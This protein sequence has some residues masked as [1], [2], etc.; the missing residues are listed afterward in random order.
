MQ[1]NYYIICLLFLNFSMGID[2]DNRAHIK[3]LIRFWDKARPKRKSLVSQGKIQPVE[4]DKIL[5]E[6]F[7][8]EPGG[9]G[10]LI[11]GNG[12]ET[13]KPEV[14]VDTTNIS[15]QYD[16]GLEFKNQTELEIHIWEIH[17]NPCK[18]HDCGKGFASNLELENHECRYTA[19]A[20]KKISK[21]NCSH[22]EKTFMTKI[23]YNY[24][25]Q[26]GRYF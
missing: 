15:C 23:G 7:G 17:E 13:Q 4:S 14:K 25:V 3:C 2:V 9:V 20:K 5:E 18:C 12:S 1:I 21:L 8:P 6:L 19:D 26:I 16:C 24:H 11:T 22:C 10:S